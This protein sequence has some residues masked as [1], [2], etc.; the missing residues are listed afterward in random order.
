MGKVAEAQADI[1]SSRK[2]DPSL[3]K[4]QGWRNKE[5]G[6]QLYQAKSL[7]KAIVSFGLAKEFT[8]VSMP[9]IH[10][11]IQ[12]YLASCHFDL[13]KYKQAL[14]AGKEAYKI[15]PGR[16]LLSK[17]TIIWQ[18]LM[19]LSWGVKCKFDLI[20]ADLNTI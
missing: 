14:E 18:S 2:A 13:G 6:I 17:L 8:S 9:E 16:S 15:R 19:C 3:A 5:Q 7:R 10:A 11:Q 12:S 4:Q 20:I 1:A